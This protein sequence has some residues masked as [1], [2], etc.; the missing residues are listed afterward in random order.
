MVA[1]SSPSLPEEPPH[2]S[3]AQLRARLQ[4]ALRLR[5]R[6]L[7][8]QGQTCQQIAAQ[9]NRSAVQVWALLAAGC[10]DPPAQGGAGRP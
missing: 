2:Q 5:A 4:E 3:S 10:S 1:S 6:R 8:A 7:S 9:T